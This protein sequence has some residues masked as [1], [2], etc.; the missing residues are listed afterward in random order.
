MV[1]S[2]PRGIDFSDHD[3]LIKL[4]YANPAWKW[5]K[6]VHLSVRG[7]Q[8]EGPAVDTERS[9]IEDPMLG[10]TGWMVPAYVV[11]PRAGQQK[12]RAYFS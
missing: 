6:H 7:A 9:E 8:F 10:A 2:S 1:T 11:C 3:D 4:E 5:I 12:G